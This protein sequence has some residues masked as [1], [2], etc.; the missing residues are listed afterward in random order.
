[1]TAG[2]LERGVGRITDKF[3]VRHGG[4]IKPRPSHHLSNHED[5]PKP[6]KVVKAPEIPQLGIHDHP[7]SVLDFPDPKE[8]FDLDSIDRR[9]T[10]GSAIVRGIEPGHVYSLFDSENDGE[11]TEL[12]LPEAGFHIAGPGYLHGLSQSNADMQ[13]IDLG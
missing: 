9:A 6:K 10:S 11:P 2:F 12:S 7:D 4:V 1:M 8:E 5:G 13:R 3:E